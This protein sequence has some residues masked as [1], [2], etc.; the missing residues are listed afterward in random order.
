MHHA[1]EATDSWAAADGMRLLTADRLVRAVIKDDGEVIDGT[2]VVLA[3]IEE[4]GEVGSD[5]MQFLGTSASGQVINAQAVV[6]G[7]YDLGKGYIKD[8]QGSVIAELSK[9]GY[10]TGNRGQTVGRVEG[11][12]YEMVPKLAAY[13]CLVDPAYVKGF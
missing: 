10:V 8:P 6:V 1:R 11:F 13:V 4:S 12:G 9:E 5:E 7:E 3:Y 2:D